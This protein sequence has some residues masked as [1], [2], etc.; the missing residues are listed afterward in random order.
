ME[1]V[2]TLSRKSSALDI[3]EFYD[4][5]LRLQL[6]VLRDPFPRE[7]WPVPEFRRA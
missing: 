7:T 5:S 6:L 4:V 2:T 1:G 3:T